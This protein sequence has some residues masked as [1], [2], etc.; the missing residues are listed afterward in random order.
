MFIR[1]ELDHKRTLIHD[2]QQCGTQALGD[3]FKDSYTQGQ[4]KQLGYNRHVS[5]HESK[6]VH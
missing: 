6:A 1:E 5:L 3:F 2:V 4:H